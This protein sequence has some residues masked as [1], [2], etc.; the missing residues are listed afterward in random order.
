MG[1]LVGKGRVNQ[2][3]LETNSPT[4]VFWSLIA[5]AWFDF[6]GKLS[7]MQFSM[8]LKQLN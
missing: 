6:S 4:K 1:G 2:T 5:N 3:T 7:I 8:G